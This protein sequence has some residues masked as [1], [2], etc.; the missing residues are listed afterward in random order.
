MPAGHWI[1][2]SWK[3]CCQQS[4]REKGYDWVIDGSPGFGM[5]IF[6]SSEKSVEE[7]NLSKLSTRRG[8][9]VKWTEIYVLINDVLRF[10]DKEK[11]F[12]G[13]LVQ[14]KKEF[15]IWRARE[16]EEKINKEVSSERPRCCQTM[17]FSYFE[18]KGKKER[19]FGRL[20]M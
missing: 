5:F 16:I 10:L 19:I 6:F 13:L 11:P 4:R 17:F 7:S 15:W 1:P 2:H 8:E 20:Q 9:L 12:F 14:T 3:T 18:Y